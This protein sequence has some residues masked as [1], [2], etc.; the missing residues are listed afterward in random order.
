MADPKL[1]LIFYGSFRS[2]R[3]ER[4]NL[5]NRVPAIKIGDVIYDSPRPRNAKVMSISGMLTAQD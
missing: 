2:H 4:D 1:A 5:T 3:T